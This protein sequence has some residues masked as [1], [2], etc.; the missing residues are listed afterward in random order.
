VTLKLKYADFT[1]VTR[2]CTLPAPTDDG[3]AIYDAACAQLARA[4]LGR[5]VRLTGITV[6]GFPDLAEGE[7]QLDLF[8]PAAPA[9]P[10]GADRRRALNAAVDAL[11]DRFGD[12]TVRPATAPGERKIRWVH[13]PK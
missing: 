12:G 9:E 7:P 13:K 3:R 11:A 4:D 2:R 10:A 5:P 1:G 6:S 8:A